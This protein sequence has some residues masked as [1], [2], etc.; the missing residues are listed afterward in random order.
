[1]F[2]SPNNQFNNYDANRIRGPFQAQYF[3]SDLTRAP[4]NMKPPYQDPII[5]RHNFQNDHHI[6]HDNLKD[7][8]LTEYIKEYTIIIDSKNRDPVLYPSPYKYSVLV[9]QNNSNDKGGII[10][11][12][13]N[14]VKYIKVDSVILPRKWKVENNA[15]DNN[16]DIL[17]DRYFI[18]NLSNIIDNNIYSNNQQL[19]RN[20]VLL[21]RNKKDNENFF[22]LTPLNTSNEFEYDINNLGKINKFD[23]EFKNDDADNLNDCKLIG[24]N[25]NNKNITDL[26]NPLNKYRQNVIILKVGIL[27]NSMS[28]L[29]FN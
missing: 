19:T 12:E 5:E 8:L 13:L 7:N 15:F 4:Y 17:N 1:M 2:G 28:K 3:P 27:E 18:L 20:S 29:N 16:T 26:E 21:S 23:I 11:K 25:P 9:N 14:N 10:L 24:I 6:I 22:K